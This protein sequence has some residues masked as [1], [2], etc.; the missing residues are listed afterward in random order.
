MPNVQ[1]L[2]R[3]YL[4]KLWYIN[5]YSICMYTQHFRAQKQVCRLIDTNL[6]NEDN[7][8]ALDSGHD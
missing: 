4:T 3:G 6:S 5:M 2:R 7:N 1:K 8:I